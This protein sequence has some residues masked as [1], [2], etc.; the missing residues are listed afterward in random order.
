MEAVEPVQMI[1]YQS[2]TYRKNLIWQHFNKEPRVQE[3]QQVQDQPTSLSELIQKIYFIFQ[4][5]KIPLTQVYLQTYLQHL[6]KHNIHKKYL[7]N[8]W[9]FDSG[10]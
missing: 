9:F 10:E 8:I 7:P 1:I 6:I 4:L 3:R 5:L 2:N